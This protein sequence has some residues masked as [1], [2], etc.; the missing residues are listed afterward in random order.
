MATSVR[1][2]CY[3]FAVVPAGS[4]LPAA[5]S[6]GP[7]AGLNLVEAGEIAAVVGHV[8]T[9]RP[10]G[11]S[12]D[13]RA[14]DR[15]V[16]DLVA[17]GTPVLPMR[18]GAVVADEQAVVD[19]LL[20]PNRA[21]FEDALATLAG[22]IQYTVRVEY[23]QDAVLR[24][25]LATRPDILGLRERSASDRSAQLRLGQLVVQALEQL[26]PADASAILSELIGTV[27]VHVHEPSAP[28][29]VLHAAFLVDVAHAPDFER[30]VEKAAA[31]RAGRLRFRLV[32]PSAA[33][34]FV[35]GA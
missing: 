19:E 26:R 24:Q 11:R 9:D 1:T 12:S 30:R 33:Y 25:L 18:F 6:A 20:V 4:T 32:G 10:L 31:Q 28:E 21:E 17:A 29:E 8:P 15:V 13:L 16:A 3:V 14:H 2:G 23:E 35:G 22:R 7:A 34:D 5:D 27:D